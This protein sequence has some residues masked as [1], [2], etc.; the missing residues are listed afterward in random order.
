M[1]DIIENDPLQ[2]NKLHVSMSNTI[3]VYF[4]INENLII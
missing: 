2:P 1:T 4:K 3:K